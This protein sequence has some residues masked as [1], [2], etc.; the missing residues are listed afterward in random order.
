MGVDPEAEW[1]Y[2]NRA[3]LLDMNSTRPE[4]M[5]VDVSNTIVASWIQEL[6]GIR[7]V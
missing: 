1:R 7:Q 3:T 6:R 5:L 2:P 4:K